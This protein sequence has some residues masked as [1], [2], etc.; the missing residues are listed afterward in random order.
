[1]YVIDRKVVAA[2]HQ[3]K[4]LGM[5]HRQLCQLRYKITYTLLKTYLE[6]TCFTLSSF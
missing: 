3:T 5:K 4:G 1:M 6:T 2:K